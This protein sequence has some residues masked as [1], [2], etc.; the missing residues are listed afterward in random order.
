M[1][2]IV[3]GFLFSTYLEL[4]DFST[5]MY[6][7]C[8]RKIFHTSKRHDSYTVISGQSYKYESFTKYNHTDGQGSVL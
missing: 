2:S 1:V 4:R 6:F 8:P 3:F 5:C 7:T